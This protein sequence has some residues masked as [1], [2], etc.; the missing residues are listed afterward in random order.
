M[1]IPCIRHL[2]TRYSTRFN[3]RH[4]INNSFQIFLISIM[5]QLWA[6][7]CRWWH[8]R[9]LILLPMRLRLQQ[10]MR[11]Q[12]KIVECKEKIIGGA[13]QKKGSWSNCLLR[14]RISYG[15]RRSIPR[16]GSL[17]QGNCRRSANERKLNARTTRATAYL[18]NAG[19]L[20]MDFRIYRQFD[21]I[22]I[23]SDDRF[24]SVIWSSINTVQMYQGLVSKCLPR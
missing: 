12:T 13:T 10:Q 7:R 24:T 22:M 17:S 14:T 2:V 8:R 1:H 4:T 20:R 18:I 6:L 15:T 23:V 5:A 21:L 3:T 11:Q 9:F 16:S 19:I